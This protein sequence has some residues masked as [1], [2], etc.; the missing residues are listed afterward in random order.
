MTK[1]A[2]AYWDQR[3]A[4]VFDSARRI[5]IVEV[6]SGRIVA[7]SQATLPEDQAVQKVLLLEELGIGTLVCGAISGPLHGMVISCGIRVIPFVAGELHDVIRAWLKG[8]L[9]QETFT[10]P[11]CCGRG[12]GRRRR[13]WN[14]AQEA[15]EMNGKGRAGG[16]G[17]GQGR[18]GG[19]GRGGGGQGRGRM[20]GPQ[21]AGVAGDCVC[22]NCGHREPHERG[23]PC[24]QRQCPK[25]GAAMTRQ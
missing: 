4:A 13:T 21:A 22:S 8:E 15:D 23:V 5:H 20:G 3:I 1:T 2:F 12:G 10:M 24:M 9:E 19:Q 25:C 7:E 16:N 17:R 14:P 11:G 18:S 6:E